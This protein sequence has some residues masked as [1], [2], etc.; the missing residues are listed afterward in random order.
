MNGTYRGGSMLLMDSTLWRVTGG[1]SISTPKGATDPEEFS[2][3]LNNVKLIDV[4]VMVIHEPSNT[5]LI[6]GS[7]TIDSWILGRVYNDDNINGSYQKGWSSA[8]ATRTPNL[9]DATGDYYTRLKPQYET[10]DANFFIS[11]HFATK[12]KCDGIQ[13]T[14]FLKNA[15][16]L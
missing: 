13:I 16:F 3:T 9:I 7:Y 14:E 12:G 6:G 11:A 10:K 8:S 1:I 4:A 5:N 2:I 15:K